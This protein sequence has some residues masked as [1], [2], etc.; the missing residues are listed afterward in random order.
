MFDD[1]R[2]LGGVAESAY[3]A[4]LSAIDDGEGISTDEAHAKLQAAD[5]P[6]EDAEFAIQRLINRGYLYQVEGRLYVTDYHL[7]EES[8]EDDVDS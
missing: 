4:L 2:P 3:K 1:E 6:K 8:P 5:F 7:G